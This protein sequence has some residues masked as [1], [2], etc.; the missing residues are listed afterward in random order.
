[1]NR[2]S[3]TSIR[4]NSKNRALVAGVVLVW[5]FAIGAGARE[6]LHYANTPSRQASPPTQWPSGVAID[7]DRQRDTLVVFV[8]PQCPC[9]RATIAELAGI[10]ARS[11]GQVNASVYF[12]APEAVETDWVRSKT[13]RDSEAIPGVHVIDDRDGFESRRFGTSTSG[14]VLLYDTGGHLVFNGGI[15]ASRGHAGDNDGADAVLSLLQSGKA[16]RST[17]PVFGCSLLSE[18]DVL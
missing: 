7:L 18:K 1:M 5:S 11:H 10:V 14:Q 16:S 8:H 6:L 9:S 4:S 3:F 15:T 12:Y 17:A 2:I 13:W